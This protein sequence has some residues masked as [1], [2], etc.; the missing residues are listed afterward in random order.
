M[1]RLFSGSEIDCS[2]D[3]VVRLITLGIKIEH[4]SYEQKAQ[5]PQPAAQFD[6][7]DDDAGDVQIDS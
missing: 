6:D 2:H 7:D 1:L 3:I 4:I 5:A